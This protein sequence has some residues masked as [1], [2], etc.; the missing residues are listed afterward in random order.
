MT[1][2]LAGERVAR[3]SFQTDWSGSRA[4]VI[5]SL[6][7]A[8]HQ[9]CCHVLP[10]DGRGSEVIRCATV[11]GGMPAVIEVQLHSW[12][13]RTMIVVRSSATSD[14][15]VEQA[16]KEIA[17]SARR[18]LESRVILVAAATEEDDLPF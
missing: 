7:A 4:Q 16:A 6:W 1:Y 5:G 10:L 12:V 13:D 14:M 11:I 15:A 18:L 9:V 2:A 17:E 8:I 3:E